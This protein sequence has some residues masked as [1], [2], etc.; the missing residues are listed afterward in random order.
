MAHAAQ[1]AGGM[2]AVALLAAILVVAFPLA[3]E[4]LV[5]RILPA[6]RSR[7]GSCA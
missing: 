1:V 5:R 4:R 3:A 2:V 7:T 6:G